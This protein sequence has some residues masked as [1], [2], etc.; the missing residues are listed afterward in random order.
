MRRLFRGAPAAAGG[1]GAAALAPM[2]DLLTILLV[3]IL[4]SWSSDPPLRLPEADMRLPLS[5]QESPAPR[6]IAID[7]GVDGLY[8]DGWR[9][10][11]TAY[12]ARSEELLVTEVYAALRERGTGAVTIRAHQQAPWSLVGKVL[13]TAQQAGYDDIQLLAVSR[14]SL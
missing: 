2:V 1:L 3:A 14:A 7:I 12:W 9:S 8:V 5:A 6:S 11:S 13:Y 10:G 4:R